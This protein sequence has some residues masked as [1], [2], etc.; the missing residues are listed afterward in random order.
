MSNGNDS[1]E[2]GYAGVSSTRTWKK[3]YMMGVAVGGISAVAVA[4]AV[5]LALSGG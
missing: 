2:G 5:A 1:F 4:F 3:A